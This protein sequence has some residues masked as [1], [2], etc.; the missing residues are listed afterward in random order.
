M[1]ESKFIIHSLLFLA[2]IFQL[3]AEVSGYQRYLSE[4]AVE[5]LR[6]LE[7]SH[8]I[9]SVYENFIV[10][11]ICQNQKEIVGGKKKKA[12]R[13]YGHA[14]EDLFSPLK[15][16]TTGILFRAK[17]AYVQSLDPH[18]T[19]ATPSFVPSAPQGYELSY[20]GCYK[21]EKIR[22]EK[23]AE[24]SLFF[25]ILEGRSNA[26]LPPILAVKGSSHSEDWSNN[27]LAGAPILR[28]FAT[29]FSTE[30]FKQLKAG[31]IGGPE[32]RMPNDIQNI[33][34]LLSEFFFGLTEHSHRIIFTGHSL[35]GALAQELARSV[36]IATR[37]N[38][39]DRSS[40]PTV[41]VVTWNGL[42]YTSMIGR[43]RKGLADK[44]DPIVKAGWQETDALWLENFQKVFDGR[45]L[46][47]VNFHTP[48]DLLTSVVNLSFLGALL[49]HVDSRER[50]HA[51]DDVLL[52]TQRP[53][54]ISTL[55]GQ[56]Y[57]HSTAVTLKDAL[58]SMGIVV[59]KGRYRLLSLSEQREQIAPR[60]ESEKR[61]A[62]YK[63]SGA[64]F[65]Q[66]GLNAEVFEK[67][68]ALN[69]DRLPVL[70]EIQKHEKRAAKLNRMLQDLDQNVKH[71]GRLLGDET[72]LL[73][74]SFYR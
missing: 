67:N 6:S 48:D 27:L 61:M 7:A 68:G 28:E 49:R 70:N 41:N 62:E 73:T 56:A 9:Y 26:K 19:G 12:C 10:P 21:R 74:H 51:G 40:G 53:I 50:I 1:R 57:A 59:E 29:L 3:N 37:R 54:Q 58:F 55:K 72:G 23:S 44:I 35:G 47:A 8:M 15:G 42:S 33:A 66:N 22:K 34:Q 25:M 45:Y 31:I 71:Y 2:G 46:S 30:L 5:N 64:Y 36:F 13:L 65:A 32:E 24:C 18:F 38:L 63:G 39:R 52:L 20:V 14:S 60:L 16:D 43:L 11:R 4:K 69:F 17:P